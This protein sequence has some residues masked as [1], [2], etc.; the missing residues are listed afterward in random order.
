MPGVQ[1]REVGFPRL[2]QNPSGNR[3]QA[4]LQEMRRLV[5]GFGLTGDARH[6]E[7]PS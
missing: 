7:C 2:S 6:K 3:K 5:L 4:R 1:K